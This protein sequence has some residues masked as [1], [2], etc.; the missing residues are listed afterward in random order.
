MH[1]AELVELAALLA[2]NAPG[3]LADDAP[4]RPQ[5]LDEYWT[6]SKCRLDRWL[7]TLSDFRRRVERSAGPTVSDW[8]RLQGVTEEIL[9]GEVL[10]RVWAALLAAADRRR[11]TEF[12]EPIG[13]SILIGHMEARNRVLQFAVQGEGIERRHATALNRL[14][15]RCDRW[16]D[17]L[18]GYLIPFHDVS[19]FAPNPDR[20]LDFAEELQD[21]RPGGRHAW[22]LVMA[23]LRGGIGRDFAEHSPNADLNERIAAAVLSSVSSLSFDATGAIRSLWM[24]WMSTIAADAEAMIAELIRSDA[25]AIA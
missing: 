20:A 3:L 18:V 15:R 25:P 23:S 4:P 13:R 16:T 2:A 14:R 17:L 22:P 21:Q 12:G 10:T 11:G 24:L 19:E 5:R 6:A 8:P 1:A 7:R 9:S